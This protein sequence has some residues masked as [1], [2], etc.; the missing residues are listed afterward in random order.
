LQKQFFFALFVK[1]KNDLISFK[2]ETPLRC[3][4][5][6]SFFVIEHPAPTTMG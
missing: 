3:P 5:P 1:F 4:R 2:T 6:G